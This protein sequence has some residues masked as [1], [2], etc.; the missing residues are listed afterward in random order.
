MKS[1]EKFDE[2]VTDYINCFMP[3]YYTDIDRDKEITCK[4]KVSQPG[5]VSNDALE[6]YSCIYL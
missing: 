5:K 6:M 2:P 4:S 3:K 1:I